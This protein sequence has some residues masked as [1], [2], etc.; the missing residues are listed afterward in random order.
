MHLLLDTGPLVA[1]LD[2]GDAWHAQVKTVFAAF[3]GRLVS[4]VPVLTE[5]MQHLQES[6]S[7]VD[8]CIEFLHVHEPVI[9]P[10]N[11]QRDFKVAATLMRKYADI[12][13]DFADASL[14][15]L[16][17]STG[18]RDI[19]TLDRRGFRTFRAHGRQA[20]HLLLDDLIS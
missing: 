3:T 13:M 12:P 4:T 18:L 15:V 10:F 19:F 8:R 20:F 6:P 11:T 5:V 16:A 2:R 14:V 1:L 7:A 9:Y 17:E